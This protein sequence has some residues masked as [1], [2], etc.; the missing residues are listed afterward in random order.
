VRGRVF[1]L[2]PVNS[3]HVVGPIVGSPI[4][5]QV[6]WTSEPGSASEET[7]DSF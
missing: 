2:D 7:I 5:R 6:A 4:S 1:V 3:W